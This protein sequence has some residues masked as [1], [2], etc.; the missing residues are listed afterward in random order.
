MVCLIEEVCH[1]IFREIFKKSKKREQVELENNFSND[2]R[3]DVTE[4]KSNTNKIEATEEAKPSHDYKQIKNY[5]ADYPLYENN[6]LD[7][8]RMDRNMKYWFTYII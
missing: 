8:N 1:I 6:V 5:M 4:R 2:S 7:K 3:E